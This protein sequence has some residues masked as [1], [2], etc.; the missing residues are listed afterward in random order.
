MFIIHVDTGV[1]VYRAGE[2]DDKREEERQSE[3]IQHSLST[4]TRY[5]CSE[6]KVDERLHEKCLVTVT[7]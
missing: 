6:N 5:C 3:N 1:T 2:A 4:V 7:A